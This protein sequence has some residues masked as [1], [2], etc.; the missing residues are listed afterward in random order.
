[1]DK[2]DTTIAR[3]QD[4]INKA[5]ARGYDASAVQEALDTFAALYPNARVYNREA[6]AILETHAGFDGNGNVTDPDTAIQTLKSLQAALKSAY[7]TMGGENHAGIAL[8]DAVK[9]FLE[10]NRPAPKPQQAE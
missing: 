6:A 10:A 8:K 4:L 2:A 9:V 7:E 5:T 1:M 3:T